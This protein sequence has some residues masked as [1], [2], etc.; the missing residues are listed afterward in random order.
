MGLLPADPYRALGV[1]SDADLAAIKTAYRRLVLKCHPDKVQDPALKAAKQDEFQRVQQAYEILSDERRR[2]EY[3]EDAKLKRLRDELSRSTARAT[4]TTRSSPK[5]RSDPHIWTAEPPAS[6]KPG[7][8]PA[9]PFSPYGSHSHPFS[10]SWERDIPYRTTAPFDEGRQARRTA[11]YENTG[12]DVKDERRRRKDDDEHVTYEW[13]RDKERERDRNRDSDRVRE[14]EKDRPKKGRSD[15]EKEDKKEKLKR[16]MEKREK[17]RARARRQDQQEKFRTKK[18]IYVETHHDSDGDNLRAHNKTASSGVAASPNVGEE[19]HSE[20]S[21]RDKS[22]RRDESPRV[23]YNTDKTTSEK[24]K[25]AA[26]YMVKRRESKSGASIPPVNVTYDLSGDHDQAWQNDSKL[27]RPRRPSEDKKPRSRVFLDD[28]DLH[29]YKETSEFRPPR[30]EKSNTSPAGAL[31]MSGSSSSRV[32]MLSRASTMDYTRIPP[33]AAP[34][35][36]L[37]E[38]GRHASKS[39]HRRRGSIDGVYVESF[40]PRRSSVQPRSSHHTFVDPFSM[41]R[42]PKT[43]HSR[44]PDDL[45]HQPLPSDTQGKPGFSKIKY[46]PANFSPEHVYQTKRFSSDDISYSNVHHSSSQYSS[47]HAPYLHARS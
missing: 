38:T 9:S 42:T 23:D 21:R 10:H 20:S 13:A 39:E 22:T 44:A 15:R 34:V 28:A 12:G 8:A 18:P 3:D 6:F 1:E 24:M 26:D 11:S 19:K 41:P 43:S 46:S 30:L 32:P 31:Y 25:Y 16:E 7:P 27:P 47:P 14:R 37:S 4:T 29:G 2:K 5:T 17:E 45:Y 36:P 40:G 33:P 35:A